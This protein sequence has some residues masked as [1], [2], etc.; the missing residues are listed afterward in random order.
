M[1]KVFEITLEVNS[2]QEFIEIAQDFSGSI[3]FEILSWRENGNKI[4]AWNRRLYFMNIKSE[5]V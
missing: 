5:V 3:C 1:K 2:A 4:C